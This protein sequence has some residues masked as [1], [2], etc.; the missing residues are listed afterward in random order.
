MEYS[1]ILQSYANDEQTLALPEGV[2]C[3]VRRD[4]RTK[5]WL[6]AL[7][8]K[9]AKPISGSWLCN[10]EEAYKRL[11]DIQKVYHQEMEA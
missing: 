7:Y 5:Y 2:T 8:D 1:K 10:D 3:V 6:I 9:R 11:S 4:K